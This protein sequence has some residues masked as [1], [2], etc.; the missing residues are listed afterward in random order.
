MSSESV[1]EKETE[2]FRCNFSV[3]EK[4]VNGSDW[5][6]G[7]CLTPTNLHVSRDS[8]ICNGKKEARKTCPLWNRRNKV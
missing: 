6:C 7:L 2:D 8:V 1:A 3:I 5:V 4:W